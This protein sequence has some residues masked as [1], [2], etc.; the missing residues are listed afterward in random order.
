M[1]R[2]PRIAAAAG[3]VL[4]AASL[5]SG[6]ALAD[7]GGLHGLFNARGTLDELKIRDRATKL[8]ITSHEPLDVAIVGARLDPGAQ[9]GWHTHPADSLVSVQPGGPS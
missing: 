1:N 4:L 7:H 9:T 3:S 6:L 2:S 5:L 8:K